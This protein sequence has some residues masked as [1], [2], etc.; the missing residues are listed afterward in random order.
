MT[1][2]VGFHF[3]NVYVN[4]RVIG[5]H[6]DGTAVIFNV[7]ACYDGVANFK[8]GN[9]IRHVDSV[10]KHFGCTVGK[11]NVFVVVAGLTN[12]CYSSFYVESIR[13]A[14]TVCEI[15]ACVIRIGYSYG[16]IQSAVIDLGFGSSFL[17]GSLF[18]H[19]CFGSS[20]L[21][22]GYF[23]GRYFGSG[24][25]GSSL[26]GLRCNL[27]IYGNAICTGLFYQ[28]GVGDGIN[29][30]IKHNSDDVVVLGGSCI[31]G[32]VQPAVNVL[33]IQ[34]GAINYHFYHVGV[35]NSQIGTCIETS[36]I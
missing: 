17:G 36:G 16:G 25:F 13:R 32:N 8:T 19:C 33:C 5:C 6:F 21:G 23:G 10:N 1:G 30:R 11:V 4:R 31:G 7:T 20:L 15:C 27:C 24:L 18:G 35:R 3:Y 26:F 2:G 14:F 28:T 34:T 22:S 29:G 12:C 9:A